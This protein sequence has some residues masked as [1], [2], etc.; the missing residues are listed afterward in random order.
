MSQAAL[1]RACGLSQ[2][3]IANY[4]NKNRQSAKE[5]FRLAEVLAVNPIWL[6]MGTGPMEAA[7]SPI[8]THLTY[9]VTDHSPPPRQSLWPFTSVP[10]E[11]YWS[12]RLE[13]RQL[14]ENT[15]ASLIQSLRNKSGGS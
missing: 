3:A 1:A 7:E 6:G 2:G 12:L 11:L 4:E 14:I 13:E 15:V 10:P 5:I 9:R 8:E